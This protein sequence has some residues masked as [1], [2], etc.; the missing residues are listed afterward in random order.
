[1]S[2]A[3]CALGLLAVVLAAC[4]AGRS[5]VGRILPQ[6][7]TQQQLPVC[8]GYGCKLRT[9]V[10]LNDDEWATVAEL[11]VTGFENAAAEREQIAVAV[12]RIERLVGP[13][14]GTAKDKGEN[15]LSLASAGELDC[16]DEAANTTTYLRLLAAKGLLRWHEVASPAARGRFFDGWPHNTAVVAEREGSARYAIDSWFFANG[17]PAAVVPLQQWLGGWRPKA[18]DVQRAD[19]LAAVDAANGGPPLQ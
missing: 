1:M 18:S 12:G 10:A 16:V 11:F 7:A 14:A 3:A 17:R 19:M 15:S 6:E 5:Q 4:A 8:H 9:M 13:K 2:R